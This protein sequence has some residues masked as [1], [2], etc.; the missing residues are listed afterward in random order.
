M[1]TD[2]WQFREDMALATQGVDLSGFDVVGKDGPIGTVHEASN[3][4]RVDYLIVNSGDGPDRRQVMLPAGVVAEVDVTQRSVLVD[5]T[6]DEIRGAPE[7]TPDRRSDLRFQ[8]TL[9][10]YYHGLYDTGL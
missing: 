6:R 8:D 7:Y 9:H 10:G 4:T 2:L 5:R 3:E 1:T